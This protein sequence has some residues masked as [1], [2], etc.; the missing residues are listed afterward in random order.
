MHDLRPIT[1]LGA[2]ARRED[3]V[4][5]LTL[6]ERPDIALASVAARLGREGEARDR[7]RAV[8]GAVPGPGE[9]QL[10][11][12][13]AG[14]WIGPDQWMVGAPFDTHEDLAA[15]LKARFGD[16]ASITEQTDAWTCFDLRGAEVE[17]AL[18]LLCNLDVRRMETGS[19]RPTVI[20]HLRCFV[21][22]RDP[23]DW[24]RVVGPRASA[25]TLH[26]AILDA[27]RSVA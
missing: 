7:L 15:R 27:M 12:P 20:H 23:P 22:R 5:A 26:H 19:A 25:D 14:F 21:T 18:E 8:I 17:D 10:H 3:A 13:E 1:A 11:D 24:F 16:T 9:V 4:G 6:T 2:D